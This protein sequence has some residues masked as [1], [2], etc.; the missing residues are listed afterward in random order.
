MEAREHPVMCRACISEGLCDPLPPPFPPSPR[1]RLTQCLFYASL[2]AY[3][4]ASLPLPFIFSLS[5]CLP[6][7]LP[8]IHLVLTH[9]NA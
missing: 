6:L 4:P 7:C 9:S 5:L 1:M 8:L 3:P 2:A